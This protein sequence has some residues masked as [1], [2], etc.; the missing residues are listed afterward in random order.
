MKKDRTRQDTKPTAGTADGMALLQKCSIAGRPLDDVKMHALAGSWPTFVR[1]LGSTLELWHASRQVVELVESGE[2]EDE[3]LDDLRR[4][5]AALGR[6]ADVRFVS[7][8]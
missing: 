3:L 5:A 8:G 1:S 7:L 4:I 2:Y 6:Q